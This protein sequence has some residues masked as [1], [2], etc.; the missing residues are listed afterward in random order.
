MKIWLTADWHLGEDRF[1]IMGRPFTS[2]SEYVETLIRNH[3][4][5]VSENDAV[6]VNGD[7]CYQKATEYLSNVAR[8]NGRK[9][10]IRG[11]HDRPLSDTDFEPYFFK[12]V[13]EGKGIPWE[14]GGHKCYITHYPTQGVPDVFNLVGHIHCAWKYQLNMFNVGVDVNHFRPV[15]S[16]TDRKSVV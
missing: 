14:F 10:L 9:I 8:F 6:I 13:P 11:D 2:P 1:D 4:A 15:D 12:I 7:V 5:V 16:D 3:N